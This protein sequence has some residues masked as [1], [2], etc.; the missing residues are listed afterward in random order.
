MRKV[1]YFEMD[2]NKAMNKRVKCIKGIAKFH[3]FG[4]DYEEYEDGIGN[5]SVAIIELED[6]KIKMVRA[7]MIQFVEVRKGE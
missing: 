3:Q 2:Y 6:G 1:K 5:F 7:D 4:F